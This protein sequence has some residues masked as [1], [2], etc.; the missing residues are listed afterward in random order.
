MLFDD[1]F[2]PGNPGRRQQV[3]DLRGQIRADF[4]QFENSWNDCADLLNGIMKMRYPQYQLLKITCSVDNDCLQ[5]CVDEYQRVVNDGKQKLDKLIN[6]IGLSKGIP[7]LPSNFDLDPEAQHKINMF[8]S[9]AVDT[10]VASF[11][12]WYVYN[13]IRLFVVIINYAGAAVSELAAFLG[14]A[15]GG[16]IAG[17][18]GFVITDL[19]AS[20]I[21]GAI[22]RKQ[23]NEAIDALT[24][25]R[26]Q[27]ADPLL[28][29][30]GRLAGVTQSIRDG[31]YKVSD[32]LM[33]VRVGNSYE[34]ITIPNGGQSVRVALVRRDFSD[35]LNTD[36]HPANDMQVGGYVA[37]NHDTTNCSV[38]ISIERGTPNTAYDF[39]LKC[40][41]QLTT[42]HTDGSGHGNA[43]A[44]FPRKDVGQA[45]AF[46]MYP[47]GAPSGNKFQSE[48]V[49]LAA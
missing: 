27:V 36:V 37:V 6:D 32:T 23:L 16:M 38:D 20:A 11:A 44:S 24:T 49:R 8:I 42:I 19:I 10:A 46:D 9:G 13:S 12:T 30:A 26:D 18:I 40:H 48:Q 45:F 33:I 2:Y 17:A 47:A 1:L 7:G 25:V 28:K 21:T 35:C 22:E 29:A 15:L 41:Y 5:Q 31:A 43:H 4:M 3:S 34:V 39:F 14:G